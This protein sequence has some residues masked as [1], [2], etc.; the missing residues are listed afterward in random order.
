MDNRSPPTIS[1]SFDCN[2]INCNGRCTRLL[3]PTHRISSGLPAA[4]RLRLSKATM[5]VYNCYRRDDIIIRD[6]HLQR[7]HLQETNWR[8]Q[9]IEEIWIIRVFINAGT[10]S[11]VLSQYISLPAKLLLLC[12]IYYQSLWRYGMDSE[13]Q[14]DLLDVP[15]S[16]YAIPNSRGF[17]PK[18][19]NGRLVTV[20]VLPSNNILLSQPPLWTAHERVDM[21]MLSSSGNISVARYATETI[22]VR[23]SS[24][25]ASSFWSVVEHT[26]P[27]DT[28]SGT[29]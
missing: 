16:M 29:A 22:A 1:M 28:N 8:I 5:I 25:Q 23:S 3:L 14:M 2:Y 11:T 27:G 7:R 6:Y 18:P 9:S 13:F 15:I 24:P 19:G 12:G 20:P 21:W 26:S 10:H 17:G 4:P